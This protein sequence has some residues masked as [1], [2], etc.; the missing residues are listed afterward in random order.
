MFI[1]NIYV[2]MW[3]YKLFERYFIR[4]SRFTIWN[5]DIQL[6]ISVPFDADTFQPVSTSYREKRKKIFTERACNI[7]YK[8]KRDT[9][10]ERAMANA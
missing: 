2:Y 9:A 8:I 4:P 6:K 1:V 5:I 10:R 7:S 3:V